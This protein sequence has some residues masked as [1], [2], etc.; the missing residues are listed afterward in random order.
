MTIEEIE[1]A[2]V[3]LP[4]GDLSRFLEWFENF[5]AEQWDRH[6]EADV[7]AG[8]FATAGERVERDFE[9]GPCAQP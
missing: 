9:A 8:K 6:I 2:V 3:D 4:P 7:K 1:S 5:M